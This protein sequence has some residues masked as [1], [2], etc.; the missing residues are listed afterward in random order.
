M[1]ILITGGVI[2]VSDKG[3]RGEREDISGGEVIRMLKDI[4]I[5]IADYEIIPD[6]KDVIRDKIKE[7][8]D[9]KNT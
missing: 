2:T 4:D 5:R 7:Y 1:D 6:E 3:S 9:N 8:T